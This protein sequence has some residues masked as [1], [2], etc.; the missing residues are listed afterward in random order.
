[1]KIK[2]RYFTDSLVAI[3]PEGERPKQPTPHRA[4]RYRGNRNARAASAFEA[5]RE[6]H[7]AGKL[8]W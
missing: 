8:R 2:N 3:E 1:M 5:V 6:A 7:A 4:V